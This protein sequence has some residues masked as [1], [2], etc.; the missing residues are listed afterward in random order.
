MFE[1]FKNMCLEIFEFDPV[2]FVSVPGLAWQA[3][4]KNI[5]VKLELIRDYDMLL[6]IEKGIRDGICQPIHRY[7]KA[8]NK[9]LKNYDKNFESYLKY[10][11]GNNLY[12]WAMS[13]KLPVNG[14]EWVKNLS[15]FNED[16]LKK[17]D[18]ISNAGYFLEVDIEYSKTLF[19]SHKDL[20]YLHERKKVEKVENLIFSIDD[21][22]KYVIHIRALKKALNHDLKLKKVHR[23]I[24]FKQKAWLKSC[25]AMN[26]ELRTE[27]KINFEPGFF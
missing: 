3:C 25:I 24:Q 27:T 7:A 18:E 6:M 26:T 19:N 8:N 22:E 11:D 15:K 16:F 13:Q 17:F 4:L 1:N 23:V 9:Y 2:Y 12:G 10:L 5:K 14:F 20:P 21:K